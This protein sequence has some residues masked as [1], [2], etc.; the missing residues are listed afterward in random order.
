[1][2]AAQA[3]KGLAPIDVKS[4]ARDSMLR[5]LLALPLLIAIGM[6]WGVPAVAARLDEQFGFVL[7][8][9]YALIASFMA[10]IA[11]M[12]VGVV[13]GF[14]LLDQ[15]D[16]GTLAALR[17][18]PVSLNGFLVY[19]IAAPLVV[20]VVLTMVIVP[21]T[22][23]VEIQLLALLVVA[24]AAAPVGPLF[25]LFLASFAN[26]KVQ[27]FALMK[28]AG[29]LNWPPVIAYFLPIGWQWAMGIVPTYWPAKLFWVL[30]AGSAG[31]P[32]EVGWTGWV[33]YFVVGIAYQ[34]LLVGLLLR[35]FNRIVS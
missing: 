19:R 2:R 23:L 18:T 24:V 6:R 20:S 22:G 34:A 9:Y 26:N 35:R 27:G 25:A 8:P 1:M 7:Q 15:R 30:E 32:G 33:P 29:I 3:I 16:D 10:M 11:P 31:S 14:L 21:I 12:L 4:V 17:V 13:I 5:W 28:A